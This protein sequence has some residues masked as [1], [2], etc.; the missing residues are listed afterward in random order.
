MKKLLRSLLDRY[1]DS[2]A[3][4]SDIDSFARKSDIENLYTQLAALMDVREIV[5]SGVR[6]GPL[7]NW[8]L[9]PDALA[10]ILA[11]IQSRESPTVLEFGAGE[12]TVAIAAA[13]ERK[14][15]GSLVTIEHNPEY[16]QKIFRRLTQSRTEHLVD[17]RLVDMQVHEPR[18]GFPAFTSYDLSTLDIDFDIAV[19][20]GP[21]VTHPS[22]ATRLGPLDWCISHVT[23]WGSIYIDDAERP[24]DRVVI[25]AARRANP[26]VEAEVLDTE[27]GLVRLSI[28]RP[29]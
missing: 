16:R 7:R 26:Q 3:R 11:E 10:I 29:Q 4:K 9:S 8:A 1:F 24:I 28:R 21:P 27:K 14:G 13:L 12:S 19:I 2:F 25:E 6:L 23:E 22:D 15:V 18:L 20:D 17:L 5:G